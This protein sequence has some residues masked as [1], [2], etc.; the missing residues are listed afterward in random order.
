VKRIFDIKGKCFK[1]ILFDL[2]GTLIDT[3]HSFAS[4]ASELLERYAEIPMHVGR[5][6]YLETSGIPFR[7]QLELIIPGHKNSRLIDFCFEE[8]KLNVA[9]RTQINEK[10]LATLQRLR[11]AD[12]KV[13]ISSNNDE[14]NVRPFA[15][16]SPFKFDFA[17]GY[18]SVSHKGSP[19]FQTVL[20]KY[21][22]TP[23]D[24]LFVGDSLS[25][26]EV[27][28][29]QNVSFVALT[30]TIHESLFMEKYDGIT[31]L[32][33]VTGLPFILGV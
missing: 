3:M 25:D 26:A 18:S 17:M 8:Q 10:T 28:E 23:E 31:C 14:S 11:D 32:Q 24:L 20:R 33:D 5:R 4:I 9:R 7:H 13:G 2:D 12:I 1:A 29:E 15:F 16:E 6:R 19:H 22:Y 30:S 27:A 21:S